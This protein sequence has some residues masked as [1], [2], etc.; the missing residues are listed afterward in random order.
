AIVISIA[1][2]AAIV[3]L[4]RWRPTW[5]G[6]LLAALAC[7]LLAPWLPGAETLTGRFGELPRELPH[8]EFPHIPF[9]RTLE[10][11]PSSLTIAFLAGVESLLSAVVADKMTGRRHRASAE[12]IAQGI[13]NVGSALI[14]GLPATGAIARTATN[15]RAGARTPVAGMLHA[16]F[17]ALFVWLFAPWL[18]R[19]PLA[20]LAAILLVVAWNI[21]EHRDFRK[22]LRGPWQDSLVMLATFSLTLAF[23]LS[24]GILAGISLA[25][26]CM[27]LTRWRPQVVAP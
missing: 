25:L 7:T 8:F 1:A 20:A 12:L 27:L 26:L 24:I 15:I 6:F 21:S 11:L 23:D 14:G 2:L 10:L 17:L 19:V 13:A 4:R 16:M 22:T 9:E 18:G 5:P 3:A